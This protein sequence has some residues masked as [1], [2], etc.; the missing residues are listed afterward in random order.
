MTAITPK[1]ANVKDEI[2]EASIGKKIAIGAG[3]VAGVAAV[4]CGA[5]LVVKHFN[6]AVEV[7][8]K[9]AEVTPEVVENA[10]EVVEAAI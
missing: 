8:E 7:A 2:K 10:A 5:V 3:V 4:T 1:L 6:K 9:V